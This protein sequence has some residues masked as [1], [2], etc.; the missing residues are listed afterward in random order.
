MRK[1]AEEYRHDAKLLDGLLL[2]SAIG[3]GVAPGPLEELTATDGEG[4]E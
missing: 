1:R 2:R 3:A 4:Q